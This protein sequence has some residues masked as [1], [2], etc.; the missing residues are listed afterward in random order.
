MTFNGVLLHRY[1]TLKSDEMHCLDFII[2]TE[3]FEIV[4]KTTLN[5]ALMI[6][7]FVY[8]EPIHDLVLSFPLYSLYFLYTF[9]YA[10]FTYGGLIDNTYTVEPIYTNLLLYVPSGLSIQLVA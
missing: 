3:I 2:S 6:F 10:S 1:K 5:F 9:S 8:D 7:F 4:I